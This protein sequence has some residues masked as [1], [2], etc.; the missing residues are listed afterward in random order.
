MK[1][2]PVTKEQVNALT[3]SVSPMARLVVGMADVDVRK[4]RGV[5]VDE[6]GTGS[7]SHCLWT[8]SRHR[9]TVC[10]CSDGGLV[11]SRGKEPDPECPA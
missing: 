4:G 10:V 11:V 9:I 5:L 1:I 2:E 3:R 8:R 6:T 7:V